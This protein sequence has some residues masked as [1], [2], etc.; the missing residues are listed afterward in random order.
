MTSHYIKEVNNYY[1]KKKEHNLKKINISKSF[2]TKMYVNSEGDH[3]LEL[4]DDSKMILKAKYD[5]LGFYNL[6]NSVWYWGWNIDLVDK[7]LINASK[8]MKTFPQY[9]KDNYNQFTFVDAEDYYFR[10]DNGNFY[11]SLENVDK[12]I[13]LALYYMKGEWYITLCTSRDGKTITCDPN[14]INHPND[15]PI[16]R[17]EYYLIKHILQIG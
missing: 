17:F 4:Y 7:K 12:L 1:D 2:N 5:L 13:K 9:I 10:T 16:M 8:H 6:S 15:N 14:S 3:I 11:T